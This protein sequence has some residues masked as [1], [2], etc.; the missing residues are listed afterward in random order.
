MNH[1]PEAVMGPG[2]WLHTSASGPK[3]TSSE[4]SIYSPAYNFYTN[5]LAHCD[6]ETGS[7]EA[8]KR[9]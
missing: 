2:V 4:E 5:P 9:I 8:D 7:R 3:P 1:G 6:R